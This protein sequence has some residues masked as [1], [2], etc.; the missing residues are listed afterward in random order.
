MGAANA[1]TDANGRWD[2]PT[3]MAGQLRLTV[4]ENNAYA[5]RAIPLKGML[6][7]A[8]RPLHVEVPLRKCVRVSGR[9]LDRV[10]K[11]PIEGVRV[12]A[13][14][15]DHYQVARTDHDGI[16]TLNQLP[17]S[18]QLSFTSPAPYVQ[19]PPFKPITIPRGEDHELPD[20]LVQQGAT[21]SGRVV[22]PD[23]RPVAGV[24]VRAVWED[25]RAES[26]AWSTN[27]SGMQESAQTDT[28]GRFTIRRVDRDAF[29]RLSAMQGGVEVAEPM[30]L[31]SE[32]DAPLLVRVRRLDLVTLVG[33]VVDAD[34]QPVGDIR[35]RI[36][37]Q[38]EDAPQ[39]LSLCVVDEG[40]TDDKGRFQS[41]KQFD[42]YGEYQVEL[43]DDGK[44]VA[45]SDWLNPAKA[46]TSVFQPVIYRGQRAA[47]PLAVEEQEEALPPE[48]HEPQKIQTATLK[49]LLVDRDGKAVADARVLVWSLGHRLQTRSS[50]AGRFSLPD[51]PR[52]GA[53][54]FV[55][56]AGF[57]FHG[58]W[59][60]PNELPIRIALTLRDEPAAPMRTLADPSL[61]EELQ[62]RAWQQFQPIAEAV[63][64]QYQKEGNPRSINMSEFRDFDVLKLMAR[65]EPQRALDYVR[66]N[67]F[68]YAWYPDHIRSHVVSHLKERDVETAL[69]VGEQIGDTNGKILALHDLARHLPLERRRQVIDRARM[70]AK[71]IDNP[72]MR[73]A[74]TTLLIEAYREIGDD[75]QAR[76][77]LRDA[78]A[79][80]P[81][82]G[83]DGRSEFARGMLAYQKALTEGVDTSALLGTIEDD[84]S[85]NRYSGN[86]AHALAATDPAA[87]E[88]IVQQMRGYSEWIPRVCHDMAAVD[89][90][91]ARRIA[92]AI[93]DPVHRAYALGLI[94]SAIAEQDKDQA[95]DLIETAYALL[96][97][98]VEAD[99][100]TSLSVNTPVATAVGM[101]P[102]VERIDPT[103]VREYVWRSLSLRKGSTFGGMS[104]AL[105]PHGDG[106]RMRLADPVLAACLSRYDLELARRVLSPPGDESTEEGVQR[107]P[108][109]YF[110]AAAILDPE[111]TLESVAAL[112]DDSRTQ[113]VALHQAWKEI[114]ASF[115]HRGVDRWN[116]LMEH[117]MHLWIIGA[118]VR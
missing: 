18:A 50:D 75:Q 73:L 83:K 81:Q 107:Y 17:G 93:E 25:E 80:V 77:L 99:S 71:E 85:H 82:L 104:M 3:V 86:I 13:H 11:Q 40:V 26:G 98:T 34:G 66:T 88:R 33:L 32:R 8:G 108:Y 70:Q 15:G 100:R 30:P 24:T 103:L 109:Y 106:D 62:Q 101:L 110:Y 112:P 14:Q 89:V 58:Q 49:G 67:N 57:R 7:D 31:P 74:T 35:F 51:I 16:F 61:P 90:H 21:L 23:D 87:A 46:G 39:F 78:E 47:K 5:L 41:T 42:R 65:Y 72:S 76:D 115:T 64:E 68:A 113:H 6:L 59:A 22:G 97:D 36:R 102:I 54:L 12:S 38:C 44:V 28:E 4:Y 117:Q 10:T 53:F 118:G 84:R 9:V 45:T 105:G 114:F 116:S 94:A 56:S 111:G 95:V 79:L 37:N 96:V 20:L 69:S 91:R 43:V 92:D 63:L 52:E 1:R 27:F 60:Q 29:V 19:V 55:E 48:G 2:V